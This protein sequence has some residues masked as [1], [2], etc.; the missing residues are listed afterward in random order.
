MEGIERTLLAN[1]KALMGAL[2]CTAEEAMNMLRV[3]TEK[4]AGLHLQL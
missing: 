4:R 3:P 1:L 2:N